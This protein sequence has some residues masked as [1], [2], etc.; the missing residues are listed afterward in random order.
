M[1][2]ARSGETRSFPNGVVEMVT[3]RHDART[4]SV[5]ARLAVVE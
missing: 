5:R 3:I 4:G 2:L 1:K